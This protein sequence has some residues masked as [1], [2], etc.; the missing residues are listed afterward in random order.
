M[1]DVRS[2]ADIEPLIVRVAPYMT[3]I[4]TD[5]VEAAFRLPKKRPTAFCTTGIEYQDEIPFIKNE[6]ET[7]IF[8]FFRI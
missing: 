7:E 6:N 4:I 8:L 5:S 1:K 3:T 2:P